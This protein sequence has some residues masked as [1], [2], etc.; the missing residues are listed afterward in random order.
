MGYLAWKQ[1]VSIENLDANKAKDLLKEFK[2]PT[3][4]DD[5]GKLKIESGI[6]DRSKFEFCKTLIIW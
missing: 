6:T 4:V 5:K 3:S 1:N 2:Y